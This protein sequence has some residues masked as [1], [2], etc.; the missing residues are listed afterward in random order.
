MLI[1]RDYSDGRKIFCIVCIALILIHDLI[2]VV[3]TSGGGYD[4]K[5]DGCKR[6]RWWYL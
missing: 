4:L 5:T 6:G 3:V 2:M 1:F